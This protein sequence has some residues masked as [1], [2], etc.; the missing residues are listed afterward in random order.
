MNKMKTLQVKIMM[1]ETTKIMILVEEV[2]LTILILVEG[3]ISKLVA[4]LS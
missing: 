1:K 2:G 4:V 3:A